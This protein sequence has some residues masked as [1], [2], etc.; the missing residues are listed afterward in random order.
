MRQT[1][2]RMVCLTVLMMVVLDTQIAK[3]T[4]LLLYKMLALVLACQSAQMANAILTMAVAECA[5]VTTEKLVTIKI[6]VCQKKR[7]PIRALLPVLFVV[8]SAVKIAAPAVMGTCVKKVPVWMIPT[9]FLR[10]ITVATLRMVAAISANA[11]TTK[12]ATAMINVSTRTS[13][14]TP[15]LL[16][17]RSVGRFAERNAALVVKTKHVT[18]VNARTHNASRPVWTGLVEQTMAAVRFVG[19]ATMRY[20]PRD[21]V[22]VRVLILATL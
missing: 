16:R 17:I 21:F 7:V 14:R 15:V 8:R 5:N 22:P 18:V 11:V 19:V 10:V 9:V 2:I 4:R 13:V 12:F 20:V 3:K 6:N 1:T